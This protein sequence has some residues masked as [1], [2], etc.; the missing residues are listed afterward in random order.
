VG[1]LSTTEIFFPFIFLPIEFF[2][3]SFSFRSSSFH[4]LEPRPSVP[5][6]SSRGS[7]SRSDFHVSGQSPSEMLASALVTRPRAAAGR[8][9]PTATMAES[10][11]H[12]S[13]PR[14]S[15]PRTAAPTSSHVTAR[16]I[17]DSYRSA[18]QQAPP[19]RPPSPSASEQP[20][21]FDD[22]GGEACPVGCVAEISRKSELERALAAAEARGGGSA[23]P[24]S[25]SPPAPS[26]SGPCSSSSA[27]PL[28]RGIV[29][30]D[31]YKTACGACK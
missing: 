10:M 19:P 1:G 31:F 8:N 16:G 13:S 9:R 20:T 4:V 29:V 11:P 7:S 17:L 6:L 25:P 14:R 21:D 28:P 18:Q 26:P 22:E 3:P 12:R 2:F 23:S 24:S 27:Y 30:V 15:H 5:P